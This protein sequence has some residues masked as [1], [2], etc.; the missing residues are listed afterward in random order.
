MTAIR[1]TLA[2][3]W[4]RGASGLDRRA[5]PG[6]GGAQPLQLGQ[7]HPPELIEK[8][9]AETGIRSPHRLRQQRHRAG[10]HPPGRA[11]LRHRRAVE[12]LCADL[13]RGRAGAA[14]RP[15]HR[16]QHR[17]HR[18]AMGDVDFDPGREYSVPWAWGT[19]GV[20]V[21]T[22]VYDGDPQHRRHLPDPPEELRGKI[23][24][25][26]EMSD[27]MHMA[28]RYA[29]G[30][31]LHRRHGRAARTRDM[32][33]AAKPH[34]IAMDYGTVDAYVAGD[35]AAG[36]YWNGAS[37]RARLQNDDRLRLSADRLPSG[38]TT[39]WCWPTRR[40]PRRDDLH[41]LHPRARERR[42]DLELRALR[43]RRHRAPSRSWT[44]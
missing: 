4:G 31:S 39:R 3:G 20:I 33:M 17:Q 19:T 27:V 28:I 9:E 11:R 36:V 42:A 44:R 25:I 15:R 5:G 37:M 35:I 12:Q 43:Q 22:S 40:T 16:H 10:P 38:W 18:P 34:W 1:N 2:V 26:P 14:A 30:D 7:L 21:N 24:V 8:F 6:A 32:L 29:G 23:N 13:D 41:Q